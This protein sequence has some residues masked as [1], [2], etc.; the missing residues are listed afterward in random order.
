MTHFF[1]IIIIIILIS[2]KCLSK[3]K[4]Y[5][6]KNICFCISL[7]VRKCDRE[8]SFYNIKITTNKYGGIDEWKKQI[9]TIFTLR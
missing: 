9:A 3:Y 6:F 7:L 1:Q 8:N 2:L 5:Y 4:S